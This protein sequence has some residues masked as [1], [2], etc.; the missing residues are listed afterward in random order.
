MTTVKDKESSAT[1]YRE[2][3]IIEIIKSTNTAYEYLLS[4]KG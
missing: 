1:K 3:T 4:D 2:K